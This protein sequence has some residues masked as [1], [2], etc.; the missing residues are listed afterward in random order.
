MVQ[1]EVVPLR[2]I[3]PIIFKNMKIIF[4]THNQG[5]V[6]EMRAMLAGL[7]AEVL[8]AEEAGVH[9]DVEEDGET[10]K[11][12]AMKKAQFVVDKTSEWAVADDSGLFIKALNGKPG[13]HTN[14]W[15]GENATGDQK[16]EKALMEMNEVEEGK[17]T[18]W[19]E[20]CLV[21]INP[22][23][24]SWIFTGKVN[25]KIASEPRGELISSLPYDVVFIP[26]GYDKTFAEIPDTEKN[27]LSH[28]GRAFEKLKVFL[29]NEILDMK[30]S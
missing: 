30:N 8:T 11:D 9:E 27:K 23:G 21:L 1:D 13:V 16:V 22:K 6:K 18:A 5:K 19:F 12:N 10:L 20:S 28:R 14:R 25:G 3:A 15:A 29:R 26:E 17:R 24:E 2:G 4:A 7:E